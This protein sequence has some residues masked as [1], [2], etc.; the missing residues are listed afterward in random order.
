MKQTESSLKVDI[1]KSFK[2]LFESID[3]EKWPLF[4]KV[5]KQLLGG[6]PL[7]VEIVANILC[8][9]VEETT[10][11]V[12]QFGET[13]QDGKVVAFAG[14]SIIPTPHSFKVNGKQLYT[15]CAA[16]AVIF[17]LFLDISAEIE[18]TD[19]MNGEPITLSIKGKTIKAIQPETAFI[20]WVDNRDI[21]NIRTTICNRIHFFISE[22]TAK[23]WQRQ[24]SDAKVLPVKELLEHSI[25][26]IDC[27]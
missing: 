2:N 23:K 15:W 20:S 24:N 10:Q 27:Y 22:N 16:D 7:D 9:S 6:N 25:N 5:Q 11:I 3:K 8:V 13:N 26:P 12:R 21:N 18:S 17:P 19:P 4:L 14:I 1:E